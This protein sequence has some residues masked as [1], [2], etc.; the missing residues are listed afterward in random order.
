LARAL[1][2]AHPLVLFAPHVGRSGEELEVTGRQR[3]R[4]IGARQGFQGGRPGRFRTGLAAQFER[5]ST[6][7]VDV[8]RAILASRS[9]LS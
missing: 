2:R 3:R 1:E 7:F 6:I 4:T 5:A 8:D 9:E